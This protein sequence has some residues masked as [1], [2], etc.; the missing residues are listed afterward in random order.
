MNIQEEQNEIL[1]GIKKLRKAVRAIEKGMNE[2]NAAACHMVIEGMEELIEDQ[3]EKFEQLRI[4]ER[5]A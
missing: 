3:I 5:D 1:K 2:K 4:M